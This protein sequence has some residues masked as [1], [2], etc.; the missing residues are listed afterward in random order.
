MTPS[1][2][3]S[4]E[5]KNMEETQKTGSRALHRRYRSRNFNELIGQEHV[6][7]TLKNA[8]ETGRIA[9]A[10][11]FSGPRGTGKTST[12]RILA[13]AINCPNEKKGQPCNKCNICRAI[14]AG[15]FMDVIEMDAASHT[16]V[17]KIREFIV[18]KVNFRP[19]EAK[20]KVY[21]IDEV[22]KL[23]SYS[24]DALLKTIEEPPPF[25]IFILATTE[26]EKLPATIVSRCQRFDFKRISIVKIVERLRE[27]SERE[28]FD[29][30]D[31][32]LNL[33]AQ[34]ADGALRDALVIL[35]QA[36]S[37]SENTITAGD[38]ISLLGITRLEALFDFAD[39]ILDKDTTRGLK[40]IHEIHME[41]K[42]LHRLTVDVLEHFRRLLMVQL[43]RDA[44]SILEVSDDL[45]DR[46]KGQGARF[47]KAHLLHIIKELIEH[48]KNLKE[49]GMERILWEALVVKLTRWEVT[50]SIENLNRKINELEMKMMALAGGKLPA[51]T[52]KKSY[53]NAL[54][55]M[56][57][58]KSE[59]KTVKKKDAGKGNLVNPK[60][61]YAGEGSKSGD[62]KL[63]DV[64]LWHKLL[65]QVK[66]TQ[67]KLV[68]ILQQVGAGKVVNDK[69][70][71]YPGPGQSFNRKTLEMHR[72]YLEDVLENLTGKCLQLQIEDSKADGLFQSSQMSHG[73]FT[74]KVKDMFSAVEV[75]ETS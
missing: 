62:V 35:E 32:A 64:G 34:A 52:S 40:F 31:G 61:G 73:Q 6:V 21:I 49:L 15:N 23:S 57:K 44:E 56:T 4:M 25:V 38:I 45:Y 8:I 12:A 14:N 5:Q 2:N 60:A 50:P 24:F 47:K 67:F 53:K 29:I 48:R 75:N 13:K 66:Q 19:V 65:R 55:T 63:D 72:R 20:K 7:Q 41:G 74:Q 33:I 46:L 30:E 68:P 27:I 58:E 39:I 3:T 18:E 28:K 36:S 42:D 37:F 43:V 26:P 9:S 69:Y 51:I 70:V 17:D 16:Q 71:L 54:S 1:G 10:Y 11:L 59:L 22:H